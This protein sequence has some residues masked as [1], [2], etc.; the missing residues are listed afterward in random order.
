MNSENEKEKK[1]VRLVKQ[2]YSNSREINQTSKLFLDILEYEDGARIAVIGK[3]GSRNQNLNQSLHLSYAG[4]LLLKEFL[5]QNDIKT[6]EK[7]MKKL[8]GD[9]CYE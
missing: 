3:R 1:S 2:L 9:S 4:I 6:L 8:D 5:E 7:I